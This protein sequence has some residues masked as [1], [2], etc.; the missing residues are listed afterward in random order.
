MAQPQL[1]VAA[2][3]R[4]DAIVKKHTDAMD[5]KPIL[6]AEDMKEPDRRGR[7]PKDKT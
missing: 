6:K 2:Q 3:K 1:S 4:L 5:G 7:P